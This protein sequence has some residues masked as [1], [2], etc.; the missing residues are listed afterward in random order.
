[1]GVVDGDGGEE[2]W[3]GEWDGRENECEVDWVWTFGGGEY[4]SAAQ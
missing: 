1:M 3:I 2:R 4:C